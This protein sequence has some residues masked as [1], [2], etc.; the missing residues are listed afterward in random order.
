SA[1]LSR[2]CDYVRLIGVLARE[3]ASFIVTHVRELYGVGSKDRTEKRTAENGKDDYMAEVSNR[4][5][6][7]CDIRRL[8]EASVTSD[9]M[10]SCY[11][12]FLLAI[13]RRRVADATSARE[14]GPPQPSPPVK[15]GLLGNVLLSGDGGP[16]GAVCAAADENFSGH[17]VDGSDI[18]H[19]EKG[20]TN[21]ASKMGGKGGGATSASTSASGASVVD[22]SCPR[23]LCV[24]ALWALSEY[25][26]LSP[27]LAAAEVLPL[28]ERL[29]TDTLEHSQI[30]KAAVGVLTRRELAT[31]ESA[32]RVCSLLKDG[33]PRLRQEVLGRLDLLMK[34]SRIKTAH[35]S[36]FALL[37]VDVAEDVRRTAQAVFFDHLQ[38]RP[39][40]VCR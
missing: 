31:D 26:V 23:A 9:G 40:T 20:G 16:G 5:A 4:A 29:A 35:L 33:D 30:R 21:T 24:E 25:A 38:P 15:N 37:L 36:S 12:P 14:E 6:M 2:A 39:D 1:S 13:V 22:L 34:E 17:G 28:A 11:T 18:R 10:L 19:G 27:E 7:E 3:N 32:A 8:R